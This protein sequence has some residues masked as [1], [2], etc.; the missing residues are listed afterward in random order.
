MAD[1]VR[2]LLPSALVFMV[3]T[4][5]RREQPGERQRRQRPFTALQHEHLRDDKRIGDFIAADDGHETKPGQENCSRA[6][7]PYGLVLHVHALVDD[8]TASDDLELL[9]LRERRAHMDED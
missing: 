7:E 3:V 1:T 9:A 6:H 2:L 5:L 8:P 4:P